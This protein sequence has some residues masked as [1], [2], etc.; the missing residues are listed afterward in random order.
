MKLFLSDADCHPMTVTQPSLKLRRLSGIIRSSSNSILK[1]SPKHSGQAPKGLLKEKLRGSTSSTLIP[2]SG[3]AKPSD[4]MKF[5]PSMTSTSTNPEVRC[6]IFSIESVRRFSMPS[7]T[8][9]RS[10]TIWILCLIFFSR[11]ISSDRSYKSPS[12]ITRT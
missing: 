10:T 1:P 2:Q 5:S 8:T 12:T 11:T 4:I 9:R 7:L 6:R 3:Q